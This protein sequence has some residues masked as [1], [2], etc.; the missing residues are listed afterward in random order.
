MTNDKTTAIATPAEMAALAQDAMLHKAR[1]TV[2]R[3]LLLALTGGGFI[4]LGFVFY[5]TSQVGADA[6]PWGVAKV[7]GG[8][9]FSVGLMLVV[10][11]GADLFTSTTMTLMLKASGDLSWWRLLRHWGLVYVGNA[12]GALT[13]VALILAGGVQ[14]SA[15]G[16]W[17]QVVL[18]TASH[19]LDHTF[20]EAVALG[21][22]CNLLVCLAVWA[23]FSGRT[24]TDKIL[25]LVGPV[26]LFVAT[27]FEHS[28]ANIFMVPL[29]ILIRPEFAPGGLEELTWVNF[30]TA[31]LIPVTLGNIVGGGLMIGLFYWL[32][33]RPK[34]SV[35][36]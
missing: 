5:V 2:G 22:L 13:I 10:L 36:H 25:A 32:V 12:V 35:A 15:G 7:L 26:A 8:L 18:A 3:T 28:V 17:G 14:H 24:T 27:G 21:I 33:F 34:R 9:V 20:L 4:A 29:G 1:G 6:M 19:K 31:N 30:V 23:A 16:Q 11:T